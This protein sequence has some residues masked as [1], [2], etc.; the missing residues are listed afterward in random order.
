MRNLHL[1]CMKE[2]IWPPGTFKKK[3]HTEALNCSVIPNFLLY[4]KHW[5]RT[6]F[7][8]DLQGNSEEPWEGG[9]SWDPL[10]VTILYAM[11]TKHVCGDMCVHTHIFLP[12]HTIHC[13]LCSSISTGL[14]IFSWLSSLTLTLHF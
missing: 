9:M 13:T 6:A 14:N 10:L 5:V 12:L 11:H 3:T 8:K 1:V 7:L 4:K 2:R